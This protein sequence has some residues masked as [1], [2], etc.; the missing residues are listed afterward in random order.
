M[1][2]V[3]RFVLIYVPTGRLWT[4]EIFPSAQAAWESL[5]WAGQRI[6]RFQVYE[7]VPTAKQ[8]RE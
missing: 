2:Q 8:I 1:A 7:L 4:E 5:G 6:N 3:S